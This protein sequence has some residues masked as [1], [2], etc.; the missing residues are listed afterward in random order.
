MS[1]SKSLAVLL[2]GWGV[3]SDVQADVQFN[4]AFL[5]G[6]PSSVADLAAFENNDQLPGSY[7][8]DIFLNGQ[9]VDTRD[10]VFVASTS[11]KDGDGLSPMLSVAETDCPGGRCTGTG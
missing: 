7:R 8:I 6:D 5:S 10:V 3:I 2:V 1:Y 9:F 11:E 4:P